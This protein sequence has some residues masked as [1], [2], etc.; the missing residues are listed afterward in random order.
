[1][2]TKMSTSMIETI[3]MLESMDK[4]TWKDIQDL[5]EKERVIKGWF[6]PDADFHLEYSNWLWTLDYS[7]WT[8]CWTATLYLGRVYNFDPCGKYHHLLSPNGV[9]KRCIFAWEEFEQAIEKL[10][11]AT[12]SNEGDP[13]ELYATYVIGDPEAR[14][15]EQKGEDDVQSA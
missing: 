6:D 3:T 7:K 8:G 9:Q 11:M 13:T 15:I 14:Y 2:K 10:G 12:V 5:M 4:P 1:M